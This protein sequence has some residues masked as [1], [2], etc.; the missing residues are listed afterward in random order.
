MAWLTS[1]AKDLHVIGYQLYMDDGYGGDYTVFMMEGTSLT[2]ESTLST[3]L[4]D[5][6]STTLSSMPIT[7][8]V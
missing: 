5:A 3:R 8:M 2:L 4:L 7:L 1:I 6:L